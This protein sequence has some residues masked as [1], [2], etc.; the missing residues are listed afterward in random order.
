[1]AEAQASGPDASAAQIRWDQDR[2][3]YRQ[4]IARNGF[5]LSGTAA[6]GASVTTDTKLGPIFLGDL[7][8]ASPNTKFDLSA[9]HQ[10]VLN[11]G[12]GND[13]NSIV[14][15]DM[16]QQLFDG[17]PGGKARAAVLQ[18]GL[19]QAGRRLVWIEMKDAL[20]NKV[21][22]SY[23]SL[24]GAQEAEGSKKSAWIAMVRNEESTKAFLIVKTATSL[25]VLQASTSTE[26]A[27]LD[28]LMSAHELVAAQGRLAL[29]LGRPWDSLL[30]AQ[31]QPVRTET[32]PD[33]SGSLDK[34]FRN[35][36]EM[37]Q[38]DL[39]KKSAEIDLALKR[40]AAFPTVNLTGGVAYKKIWGTPNGA[41]SGFTTGISL[42]FTPWD[43]GVNK[44]LAVSAQKTLDMTANLRIQVR[45]TITQEVDAAL[46][47]L[48]DARARVAL[49]LQSQEAT[50]LA[51]DSAQGKFTAG[52]GGR[53]DVLNALSALG[54]TT[55]E[56]ALART[57]VELAWLNLDKAEGW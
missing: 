25:D 54:A 44:S 33:R 46:F 12:G 48:Q 41:N 8:L 55:Y 10:L 11:D 34:A 50:S 14:S 27:R 49:A 15:L 7:T 39:D 17:Y 13:P 43:G 35:R 1:M 30:S 36:I 5:A 22:F 26:R 2:E 9:S 21:R 31:A 42:N 6:P 38:G 16:S 3:T 53:L 18:A 40:A 47:A 57:T 24:W 28:W 51:S 32:A 19:V 56:L 23:V 20:A 29:L 37:N 4:T 52:V 45:D